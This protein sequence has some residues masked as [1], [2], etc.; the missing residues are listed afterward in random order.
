VP[1]K[2]I[3]TLLMIPSIAPQPGATKLGLGGAERMARNLCLA[4]NRNEIEP[5]LLTLSDPG[6]A[7]PVLRAAGVKLFQLRKYGRVDPIF[8][9]QLRRLIISEQVDAVLSMLQGTNTHNLLVSSTVPGVARLI[10]YRGGQVDP[11]LAS[12][13]GK[14][15]ALAELLLVPSR[16]LAEQ[17]RGRYLV[18]P[19]RVLYIANGC[20]RQRFPY[21][22]YSDRG[23]ARRQLQLPPDAFI[24]YTP[25]RIEPRKGQD[26]LATALYEQR[27]L[28]EDRQAIW[29]NTGPVQD[30]ALAARIDAST[31]Q[32]ARHVRLLQPTTA[33][34]LWY[35]AAD[36]VVLPSRS[37]AF[38]N[39]V[40][41]AAFTGRTFIAT[42]QGEVP[43]VAQRLEGGIV[44]DSSALRL[45]DAL[46]RVLRMPAEQLAEEGRR[47]SLRAQQVYSIE[48]TARQFA[49]AIRQA[50]EMRRGRHGGAAG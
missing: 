33:T 30:Q 45:A 26:L 50:C 3:R 12:T 9:S 15:A 36:V 17:L 32:I 44:C 22:P 37:E 34:E 18:P 10:S 20:D 2:P 38:P 27:Q 16:V 49:A 14:L 1:V 7:E 25:S 47:L 21:V 13:E 43:E 40:L 6:E 4:F 11:L 46:G 28:L 29:I 31:R 48:D 39:A 35:A 42:A 8:W 41:E 23:L 19:D 24:L 5:L